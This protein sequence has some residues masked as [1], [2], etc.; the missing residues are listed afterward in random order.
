MR[1]EHMTEARENL[2]YDIDESLS[3]LMDTEYLNS[4]LKQLI[5]ADRDDLYFNSLEDY[6]D[7]LRNARDNIV[8]VANFL[9]EQDQRIKNLKQYKQLAEI[10][11]RYIDYYYAACDNLSGLDVIFDYG[12]I[13]DAIW[14]NWYDRY[15][16]DDKSYDSG[17]LGRKLI[18]EYNINY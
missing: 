3:T 4:H 14:N 16:L 15:D 2:V 13:D 11:V 9:L 1:T 18:T 8:I 7:I 6:D 5:D 10:L 17:C 12:D